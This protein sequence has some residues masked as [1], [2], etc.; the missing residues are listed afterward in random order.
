MKEN[1]GERSEK[2]FISCKI[3][4]RWQNEEKTRLK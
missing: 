4:K 2:R 1:L 3:K